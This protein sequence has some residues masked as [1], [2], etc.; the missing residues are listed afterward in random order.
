MMFVF[1]STSNIKFMGESCFQSTLSVKMFTPKHFIWLAL[2][3]CL[4]HSCK[5]ARILAV[6]P[7][8]SY[9]HQIA[10]RPLWKEL[11]LRGHQVV[12]LTTDP[13]NDPSLTNLT[14]V[15]MHGAYS[16]FSEVNFGDICIL[17]E[18]FAPFTM[19]QGIVSL[20][21]TLQRYQLGLEEVRNL[22]EN[23]QFDLVIAEHLDPSTI[24]YGELFDCP[25]IAITSMDA[26]PMLHARMGNPIHPTLYP[27]QDIA[28]SIPV[29]FKER[30][31]QLIFRWIFEY[32]IST[33]AYTSRQ[34]LLSVFHKRNFPSYEEM[35]KRVEV[36]FI[37]SNPVFH[38]TRPLTPGTVNTF[39]LHILKVKPL[40]QVYV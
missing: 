33:A 18:R 24:F 16:I 13:M 34:T 3:L 30:L 31:Y 4:C 11:S 23:A 19:M 40:P 22:V 2:L 27:A 5:T 9:S 38:A 26:I 12:L 36:S 1:K 28:Y 39:G 29:R 20:L 10:Y 35:L 15:D 21:L 14:E 7:V 8:P 17:S 32:Y 37:N 25:I 6:V